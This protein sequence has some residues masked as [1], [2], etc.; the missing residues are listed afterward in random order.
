MAGFLGDPMFPPDEKKNAA[1]NDW[2]TSAAPTDN[3]FKCDYCVATI[4]SKNLGITV[5][6]I[7]CQCQKS[8]SDVGLASALHWLLSPDAHGRL[9]GL[10]ENDATERKRFEKHCE[11]MKRDCTCYNNNPFADLPS[12]IILKIFSSFSRY[13]LGR[14]VAPV[15]HLFMWCAYEPRF[16]GKMNFR[17]AANASD[18]A[19]TC[20]QRGLHTKEIRLDR[21]R[22]FVGKYMDVIGKS[23]PRLQK[24]AICSND[25]LD[26]GVVHSISNFCDKTL[27][28]LDLSFQSAVDHNCVMWLTRLKKLKKLNLAGCTR[29]VDD[30][31]IIIGL[32]FQKL[33]ALNIE[34]I[35]WITDTA[36]MHFAHARIKTL[37]SLETDGSHL[38]S[39]SVQALGFCKRLERLSFQ[40]AELLTDTALRAL[41]GLTNLKV[42]R[43]CHGL[44]F[45]PEA[46]R[47]FFS[48]PCTKKLRKLDFQ[49]CSQLT[50][51]GVI[52]MAKGCGP[53]L[54]ILILNRCW[55]IRD[56]GFRAIVMNCRKL[57]VLD[58]LGCDRLTGAPLS[59]IPLQLP[60]LLSLN[61]MQCHQIQEVCI[62]ELVRN[63]EKLHVLN[64][65][66]KRV[67]VQHNYMPQDCKF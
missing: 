4:W 32:S 29:L 23:C 52:A 18:V 5:P 58:L 59:A 35:S 12:E 20:T 33:E 1:D 34:G 54:E 37:K 60:K 9:Q 57:K 27:V 31:I 67:F 3:T 22:N 55:D 17:P 63:R 39:Q 45:S 51:E 21:T 49:Q 47:V 6:S 48:H 42:L 28:E 62:R 64:T 30:T 13:Q 61:I 44:D 36:I 14:T 38:T 15:C 43:M 8:S 16:W 65:L 41:K 2:P 26:C 53:N 24:L 11:R 66:G 19:N 25:D 50:D 56:R 7:D 40:H 46:L 10:R